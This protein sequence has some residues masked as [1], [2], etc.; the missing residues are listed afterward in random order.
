MVILVTLATLTI[1]INLANLASPASGK[2]VSI[3]DIVEQTFHCQLCL[4]F[5]YAQRDWC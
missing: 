1:L 3:D 2:A 4:L 5:P